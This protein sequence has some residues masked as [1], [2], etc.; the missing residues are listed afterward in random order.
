MDIRMKCTQ[1]GCE[2]LEEVD[3]PYEAKLIETDCGISPEAAHY[4]LENELYT[5]TYICTRC[6][7][8]E[9]FNPKLA[10]LILEDR[11]EK[12][13]LQSEIDKLNVQVS[14]IEKE[15]NKIAIDIEMI[16][17]QFDDLD[18]TIR[19]SNELKAKREE[20]EERKSKLQQEKGAL[21]KK[22]NV[23]KRKMTEI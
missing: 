3:F 13:A 23:L 6:G 12:A 17:K 20:L 4:E 16:T 1:C 14:E 15:L 18:I 11:K 22:R 19:Q 10:Q 7:H 21:E 2:D 9:F 5:S 8:F